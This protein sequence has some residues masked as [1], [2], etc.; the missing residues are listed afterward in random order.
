MNFKRNGDLQIVG[1]ISLST[2]KGKD[3]TIFKRQLNIEP[4]ARGCRHLGSPAPTR[5]RL[6]QGVGLEPGLQG[7][8]QNRE[9]C[10][11]GPIFSV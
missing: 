11:W 7:S 10:L 4:S 9:K 6:G 3:Q 8:G 2:M 5:Q 1:I